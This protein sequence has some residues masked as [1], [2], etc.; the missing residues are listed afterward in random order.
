[1]MKKLTVITALSLCAIFL[2]LSDSDISVPDSTIVSVESDPFL[3]GYDLPVD[4]FSKQEAEADCMEVCS[5]IEDV[6]RLAD[7][8]TASNVVIPEESVREIKEILA[9]KGYTVTDSGKYSDM[10][11]YKKM[12][13]YLRECISGKPGSFIL[14]RVHFDGGI[15]RIRY[16]FDGENMYELRATAL[17][18]ED[19]RPV[20]SQVTYTRIRNWNYTEKG[21]LCYELCVPEYPEV[22]EI[23]DGSCL[24]RVIPMS[25]ENREMT[26]KYVAC[27]GYQGNNLL[28]SDW[29]A[30]HLQD[31]DYNGLYEYLYMLKYGERMDG[32]TAAKGIPE[33]DFERLIMSYIPV[34][35]EQLKQYAHYD[36]NEKVYPWAS[37]G[38]F[39]YSPTFFGTSFPEVTDV[40][41][42]VD[43]TVTLTVDAVCEMVLCDDA[44]IT[45]KLTIKP[46]KDGS[47]KYMGNEIVN[48][49][50]K[51]IPDYQYRINH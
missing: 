11:N 33:E 48:D 12:D 41:D 45:H 7:K 49:G 9:G 16:S 1:M 29:D 44:L 40:K 25:D 15:T 38:C 39:N 21:W 43:G 3:K 4:E 46:E 17:W 35:S 22:T 51:N 26:E 42:N 36:S 23:V 19:I 6:Y 37:L 34:T 5:L 8:G 13:E 27:L 50:I 31:L 28:C 18:N 32:E 14:Y 10:C 30:E 24:V 47:F 2:N 20:I